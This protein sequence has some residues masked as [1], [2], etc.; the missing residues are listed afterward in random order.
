MDLTWITLN[1]AAAESPDSGVLTLINYEAVVSA[2]GEI[3]ANLQ[4]QALPIEL[5]PKLVT[6]YGK[7]NIFNN[8]STS[9]SFFL[10]FFLELFALFQAVILSRI[11]FKQLW[12]SLLR[13][14]LR[15]LKRKWCG[16]S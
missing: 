2:G 1:P 12:F 14:R 5:Y 3:S 7:F 4:P 13:K 15:V 6:D 10:R 9:L 11:F 8:N 16:S